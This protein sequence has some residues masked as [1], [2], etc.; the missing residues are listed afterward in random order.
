MS[1]FLFFLLNET[2]TKPSVFLK[3]NNL[4]IA[5]NNFSFF[6]SFTCLANALPNATI[7]HLVFNN[8][9]IRNF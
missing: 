8:L 6:F 5:P 7:G 2:Y 1:V 4:Y 9:F 3:T